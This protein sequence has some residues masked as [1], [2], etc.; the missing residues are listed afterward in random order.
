[1]L[2]PSGLLKMAT[3]KLSLFRD[4]SILRQRYTEDD[5][6]ITL[7]APMFEPVPSNY[8]ISVISVVSDRGLHTETRPP[9]PFKHLIVPEKFPAPSIC[10]I[11]SRCHCP[12]FTT[13]SSRVYYSYARDLQQHPNMGLPGAVH[14]WRHRFHRHVSW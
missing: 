3:A 12:R 7:T 8:Y 14:H 6:N 11:L 13:R 5:H 1:M 10:S 4:M 2:S 9:I